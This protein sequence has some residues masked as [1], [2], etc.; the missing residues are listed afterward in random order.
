MDPDEISDLLKEVQVLGEMDHP[1]IAK[2]YEFYDE[3]Y[4]YFLVQEPIKG[5][6]L[7]DAITR[8]KSPTQK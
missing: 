7:F 5:G 2:L 4:E 6:E 3:E 8:N 1:N